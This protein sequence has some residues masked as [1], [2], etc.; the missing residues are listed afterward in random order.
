MHAPQCGDS[1]HRSHST[2]ELAGAAAAAGQPGRNAGARVLATAAI[3]EVSG[4]ACEHGSGRRA[5]TCLNSLWAACE[6]GSVWQAAACGYSNWAKVLSMTA[7]VCG[8]R[9]FKVLRN[10]QQHVKERR[11]A[12]EAVSQ[13]TRLRWNSSAW[14]RYPTGRPTACMAGRLVLQRGDSTTW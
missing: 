14:S 2:L 9:H 12:P 7:A 13:M 4:P 10:N 11:A 1:L 8:S 6:H 5:A 3:G